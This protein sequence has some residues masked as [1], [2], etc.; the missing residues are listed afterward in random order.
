MQISGIKIFVTI[1]AVISSLAGIASLI[2]YLI[3]KHSENPQDISGNWE[4]KFKIEKSSYIPYI[5]KSMTFKLFFTQEKNKIEAKGE[6]WWIDDVEI[7][8]EQ[9][10]PMELKGSIKGNKFTCTYTLKGTKRTTFGNI[11]AELSEDTKIIT[12][13]FT[14]T[15]ADTKGSVF[16][17]KK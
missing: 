7:P 12:G 2:F 5:D 10:D 17:K 9:H 14:G 15:A 8:F 6:K 3:D 11:E 1:I 4:M 16:G 13:V